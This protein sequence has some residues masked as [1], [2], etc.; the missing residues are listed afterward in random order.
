MEIHHQ[1]PRPSPDRGNDPL[2]ADFTRRNREGIERNLERSQAPETD[3]V[4]LSSG[5][6]SINKDLETVSE[7]T[8]EHRER[9]AVLME[10]YRQGT[11]N[12]PERIERAA[13]GMLNPK[14]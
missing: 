2:R 8:A 14:D 12:S 1:P 11:L 6:R 4:D 3:R 7:E 5:A 9:V 13:E 10:Q